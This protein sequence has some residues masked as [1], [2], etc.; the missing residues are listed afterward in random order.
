MRI[1]IFSAIA[2][3]V[4]VGFFVE[5]NSVAIKCLNKI[6]YVDLNFKIIDTIDMDRGSSYY[7]SLEQCA[8]RDSLGNIDSTSNIY[9]T[10]DGSF[11][12]MEKLRK[13]ELQWCALPKSM[14][15]EFGGQPF[16]FGDSIPVYCESKPHVNGK[17]VVHDVVS[18]QWNKTIDFLIHP[19]NN[20]NPK[21]GIP[22][23]VKILIEK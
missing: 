22:K 21:L 19:D 5:N 23:D 11:I 16:S 3:Q 18:G 15:K 20:R 10:A 13:K 17:W 4:A 7:P 12:N 9:N 6:G 14:L 2:V 1:L 8:R